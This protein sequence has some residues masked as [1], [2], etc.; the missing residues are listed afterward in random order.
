MT[1][2]ID[3]EVN[4]VRRLCSGDEAAFELLVS[5]YHTSMVR[6]ARSYVST[7]TAAEDV[8]QEAWLAMLQGLERFEGRSTVKTWLF[9]ILV[10]RA[11]SRGI[12]DA[13]S[14]PFSSVDTGGE[15]SFD[16]DRALDARYRLNVDCG[17]SSVSRH[18]PEPAA[19]NAEAREHI[20]RALGRLPAAQQ[21]VV[22]LRDVWG[23]TSAEVCAT[24]DLTDA[25]QRVLLHRGRSR[26]RCFLT[27]SLAETVA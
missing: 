25:N 13:R 27:D 12:R 8:A 14:S 10:N 2:V 1:V 17:L 11:K 18:T 5:R 20:G 7:D 19:I 6:M 26:L 3:D 15:W 9:R 21:A 4:L 23:F 16:P 22:T 24:L